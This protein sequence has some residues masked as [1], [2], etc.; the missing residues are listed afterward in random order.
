MNYFGKVKYLLNFAQTLL[1]YLLLCVPESCPYS[2][3]SIKHGDLIVPVNQL[4]ILPLIFDEVYAS[5]CCAESLKIF[6][7]YGHFDGNF[8]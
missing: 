1:C 3:L 8:I 6:L 5:C 2:P 7:L 4:F